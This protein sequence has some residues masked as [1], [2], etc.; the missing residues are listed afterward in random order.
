MHIA[1]LRMPSDARGVR[2]PVVVNLHGGFWK[3]TWGLH[4][5]VTC[6]LLAAF[7]SEDIASWDVEYARVDQSDPANSTAGGGWP[8]TCLDALAAL[9]A[10][11]E[12]PPQIL[13]QL[14]LG[15]VYLCGHSAGGHLALWLAYI[16][17]LA[18][19]ELE[20]LAALV[21]NS[22]GPEAAQAMQQGVARSLSVVGVIGLA[23][24]TS[25]TACA[26]AGL[27]DFHD[28]AV[29][30]LWRLGPS[31]SAALATGELGAAC[32]MAHFC[33][34]MAA[35]EEGGADGDAAASPPPLRTLLVHGLADTDVPAS[36]SLA[37]AS[38]GWSHP[39]PLPL[40]LILLAGADHYEAA[41]LCTPLGTGERE[42]AAQDAR[43]RAAQGGHDQAGA[44]PQ[45]DGATI[46]PW[47]GRRVAALRAFVTNDETT[48]GALSC[49]SLQ[50]AEALVAEASPA[51]GRRWAHRHW[52]GRLCALGR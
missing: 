39:T 34:L 28:A 48:L 43:D 15:R 17:R 6:E 51:K 3:D 16:S 52:R 30:F 23:P 40:S 25:L 36:L 4:N 29:N 26:A 1:N 9:N 31:G 12:L 37:L 47:A 18:P 42:A 50:Q 21:G 33:H 24:V 46:R 13:D 19:A 14:D 7:G 8:H 45:V 41:G 11:T 10:L 32:P 38:A 20:R 22:A 49:A 5:L 35:M 27:S 44:T 2:A